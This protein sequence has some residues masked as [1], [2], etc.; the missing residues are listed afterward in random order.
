MSSSAITQDQPL[1][2]D[3]AFDPATADIAALL[4]SGQSLIA[5]LT[6]LNTAVTDDQAALSAAQ[7]KLQADQAAANAA[8]ANVQAAGHNLVAAVSAQF[9]L[10][11]S[12]PTIS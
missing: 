8:V 10:T 7:T 4:S 5:T 2:P 12:P 3:P 6:P 9:Y 1:I 11:A